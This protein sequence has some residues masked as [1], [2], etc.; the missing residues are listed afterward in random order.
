M[1][2]IILFDFDGTI[3]DTY[4]LALSIG[5][6][7]S[8]S[9]H[10]GAMS[11]EEVV[12]FRNKP[13]RDAVRALKVPLHKIP[14]LVLRIRQ[15]IHEHIDEIR[16]F[17]GIPELIAELRSRCELLGIVTS[18]SEENVTRFLKKFKM[19][20]F[21]IGAYSTSIFGKASKLRGLIHKHGLDKGLVLYVGDTADDIDACK[22]AGI[23]IA[24]VTWGYN[25]RDVLSAGRPDF[26]C[27]R[28]E[29]LLAIAAGDARI[30]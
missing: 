26:L 15:E 6:K 4:D 18:N 3:A 23:K 30:T 27:D 24:A 5:K 8:A 13:L 11:E 21:K 9:L 25:T 22:K 16:P 29:E 7:I 12:H 10:L 2:P 19:D 20:F 14:A 17:D 28:P 1:T